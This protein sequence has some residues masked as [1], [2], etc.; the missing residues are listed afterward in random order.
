MPTMAQ[1]L[2]RAG[3]AI[4]AYVLAVICLVELWAAD[5][6]NDVK[7]VLYDHGNRITIGRKS[8][9]FGRFATTCEEALTSA[10]DMAHLAVFPS[11]INDIEKTGLSVE[12][13]YPN[14]RHLSLIYGGGGRS[15]EAN[16]LLIELD[17]RDTTGKTWALAKNGP[18]LLD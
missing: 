12:L 6:T 3:L 4:I 13:I 16:R 1:E 8:S 9:D 10:P 17:G 11:T 15:I 2:R 5:G 14:V 7:A 18:P